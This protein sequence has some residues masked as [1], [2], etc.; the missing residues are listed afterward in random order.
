M[1]CRLCDLFFKIIIKSVYT[2]E[3][4]FLAPQMFKV[5]F[6]FSAAIEIS[7]MFKLQILHFIF[8]PNLM[9]VPILKY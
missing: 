6:T 1:V 5:K 8:A 2:Q 7:G 9:F 4:T 3:N